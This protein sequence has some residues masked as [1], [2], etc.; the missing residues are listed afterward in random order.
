MSGKRKREDEPSK[1]KKKV[2][3]DCDPGH[4]DASKCFFFSM[5]SSFEKIL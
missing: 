5:K 3:L 1:Q 2:W 4:D